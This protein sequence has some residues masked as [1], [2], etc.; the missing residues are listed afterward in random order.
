MEI[1]SV[2]WYMRGSSHMNYCIFC[3]GSKCWDTIFVASEGGLN[4][5]PCFS[6]FFS[7]EIALL[8]LQIFMLQKIEIKND[9]Q[10]GRG[11]IIESI[12][13]VNERLFSLCKRW[14]IIDGVGNPEVYYILFWL[15]LRSWVRKS[16]DVREHSRGKG[17]AFCKSGYRY[18]WHD[19]SSIWKI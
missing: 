16:M 4:F 10:K 11:K 18:M 5:P 8:L 13:T 2:L 14:V 12:W 3:I 19:Y 15:T 7:T 1:H 6:T 9:N 17:V